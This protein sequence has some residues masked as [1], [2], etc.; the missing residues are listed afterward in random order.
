[1]EPASAPG[2]RADSSAGGNATSMAPGITASA[3]PTSGGGAY[4]AS[5]G[6]GAH[7]GVDISMPENTE[8]FALCSGKVACV[9]HSWYHSTDGKGE[10]MVSIES[11][12]QVGD[13]K[14]GTIFGYGHPDKI[15]VKNGEKVRQGDKLALSGSPGGGPHLH[16]FVNT[17]G[18]PCGNGNVDPTALAKDLL[19][20]G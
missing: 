1:K 14:A 5:R 20:S 6:Y 10:G 7:A 4:G 12:E 15:Y 13:F 11:D 8:L 19:T 17:E 16:F 3:V 18:K 9:S 2:T